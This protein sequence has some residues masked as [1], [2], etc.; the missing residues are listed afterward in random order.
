MGGPGHRAGAVHGLDP[1]RRGSL[2]LLPR[3]PAHPLAVDRLQHPGLAAARVADL[4]G[5]L[6][7]LGARDDDGDGR[8]QPLAPRHRAPAVGRTVVAVTRLMWR[9]AVV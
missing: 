1:E 6:G 7:L 2:P 5:A 3:L 9:V 4:A 8:A